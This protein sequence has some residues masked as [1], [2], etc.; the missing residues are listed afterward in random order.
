MEDL[1]I[2]LFANVGV[3]LLLVLILRAIKKVDLNLMW[4]LI[5][6]GILVC[7]FFALFKGGKVI[8]LDML[9]P[10]L[11]WNWSGKIAAIILWLVVLLALIKFKTNFRIADAGFTFRQ[12]E[13]SIKPAF[14]VMCLF[15]ILQ[16]VVSLFWS[17][18]PSYDLETLLYQA[19]MPGFDEEPMFRGILLFCISLA[20][21]SERYSLGGASINIAGLLLVV[22][23]GLV[24][25]V[26]FNG[27]EW[28][29]S[30]PAILL[31]GGYGFILLWLRERTGSLVFPI[32]AH[33][34][35]NFV[36]QLI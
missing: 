21:I 31:T 18:E 34:S 14:T 13:N 3:I 7:Y 16:I 26:M 9:F 8:P 32:L 12:N 11:S 17:G 25:G 33:N 30:F 20:I 36:G 22:L 19:T 2:S 24:H 6:L 10:D 23:F 27:G 29:F 35:V 15:I 5:S 1:F 4:S 28:H